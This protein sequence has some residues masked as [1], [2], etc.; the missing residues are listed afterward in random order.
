[1]SSGYTSKYGNRDLKEQWK[2]QDMGQSTNDSNFDPHKSFQWYHLR[3]WQK[4]TLDELSTILT[5]KN[6]WNDYTEEIIPI[7]TINFP[8]TYDL[9]TIEPKISRIMTQ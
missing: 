5:G 6:Q 8:N 7:I 2:L 1:M 4:N 3:W 9:N